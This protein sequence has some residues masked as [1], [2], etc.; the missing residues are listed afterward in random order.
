MGGESEQKPVRRPK[1]KL[2]LKKYRFNNGFLN[3]EKDINQ[4]NTAT[5]ENKRARES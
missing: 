4:I 1:R 3:F 5:S 2:F